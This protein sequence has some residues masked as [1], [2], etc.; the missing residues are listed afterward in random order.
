MQIRV[1]HKAQAH[2]GVIQEFSIPELFEYALEDFLGDEH[3]TARNN[4]K[5]LGRI[6]EVMADKLQ[7]TAEEVLY[8]SGAYAE[9]P[10]FC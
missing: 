7:L 5:A 9:N 1:R 10:E 4:S 6:C 3:T 2:E 8:I